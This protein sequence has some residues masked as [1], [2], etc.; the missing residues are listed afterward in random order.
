MSSS[1]NSSGCL[2][3]V[4]VAVG[5]Y[6]VY[7]IVTFA[8]KAFAYLGYNFSFY[9]DNLLFMGSISPIISWAI[10]GLFAGSIAGVLVA[11]KKYNL[12]RLLILY[13]A[14]AALVFV[15]VMGFVNKP[16]KT[17]GVFK[18]PE[19]AYDVTVPAQPEYYYFV[20]ADVNVRSGPS[21][22]YSKQFT[23]PRGTRVEMVQGGFYDS[24]KAEWIKI[25]YNYKVGYINA[26]YLNYTFE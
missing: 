6:V 2:V 1:N 15:L 21:A 4:G 14:G 12:S 8:V 26:R 17:V 10:S 20:T 11:V 19:E 7:L 23:L 13:P 22:K 25:K 16:G 18:L 3:V 5:L 24:R 9:L